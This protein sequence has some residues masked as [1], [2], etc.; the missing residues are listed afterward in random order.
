[1]LGLTD[2]INRANAEAAT[3]VFSQWVLRPRL[4]RIRDALNS[5]LLPLFGS[6]GEG[7]EF[8]F[9]DPSPEESEAKDLRL[10]SKARAAD[11][12][13]KAGFDRKAVLETVGLPPMDEREGVDDPPPLPAGF[14][15]PGGNSPT[16]GDDKKEP[17]R[18][19]A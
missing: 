18:V 16:S 10:E 6:S 7:M 17:A 19:P 15:K 3:E 13:I 11:T 5:Q 14:G 2:D 12:L 9:E 4:E 8:D 1:M